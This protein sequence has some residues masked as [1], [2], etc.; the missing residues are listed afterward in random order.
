[1]KRIIF[2]NIFLLAFSL[3][4]FAQKEISSLSDG[5]HK[6]DIDGIMFDVQTVNGYILRGNAIY[7]DGTRY[8]GSWSSNQFSGPGTLTWANGDRYEGKFSNGERSGYGTMYWENGDKYGGRWR[9]GLRSGKGKMWYADGK[10]V[11]GIWEKGKLVTTKKS[12]D[13]NTK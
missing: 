11:K 5:W 4:T 3:T 13:K 8:S 2:I 1:M 10:F 12:E 6:F 7:P 9:G